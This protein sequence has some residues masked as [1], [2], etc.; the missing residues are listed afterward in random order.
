MPATDR[1]SRVA[2]DRD[3][4]DELSRWA[5][6]RAP[7]LLARA[8]AEAV[9]L[10]RDALVDAATDT[11]G[12]RAPRGKQAASPVAQEAV[13]A[14]SPPAPAPA[15]P[16]VAAGSP[17]APAPERDELVWAYCVLRAGDE[18]PEDLPGVHPASGVRPVRG[19]D[20]IAL[21]SSVPR[22]QFGS[23][24]LH[25]NMNDIGWLERV[26]RAHERVLDA[27]LQL[28]TIV[29]LRLCTLYETADGVARMLEREHDAFA[30]ALQRLEGRAEWAVKVLIDEERLMRAAQTSGGH[31]GATERELE[32]QSEAGAYM[33]RRRLEREYRAAADALA[34]EVAQEVHAG[35]QGWAIDTVTRP[36]QNRELSGHEGTMV[37]NA[38]YLLPHERVDELRELVAGLEARYAELGARIELSGPWPP[39][40]FVSADTSIAAA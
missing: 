26:A 17:P 39:Y 38:A 2:R 31:N 14:E 6:V 1:S 15:K 7:S 11:A 34:S 35:L 37:L 20:L 24:P 4:D 28:S 36:P 40:N 10:L 30:E 3:V 16:A 19:D 33:L 5:A 21:V 32:G 22:G 12:S 8:E 27:T 23:E 18:F 25:R 9:A 13:A 29:P